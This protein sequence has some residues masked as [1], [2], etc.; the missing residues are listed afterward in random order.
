MFHL[1]KVKKLRTQLTHLI[2][3]ET[4]ESKDPNDKE[5]PHEPGTKAIKY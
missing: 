2:R 4:V 1:Q 3:D 5:D